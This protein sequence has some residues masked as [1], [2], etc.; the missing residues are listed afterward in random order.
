[1]LTEPEGVVPLEAFTILR[2]PEAPVLTVHPDASPNPD[3]W[4]AKVEG[5]LELENPAGAEQA[6]EAVVHAWAAT[7]KIVVA[8]VGKAFDVNV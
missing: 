3:G 1:M 5:P 4:T 2:L 6:P 7:D 8:V